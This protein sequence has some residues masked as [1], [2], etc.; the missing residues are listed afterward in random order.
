LSS[1][2]RTAD[3]PPLV[4]E[5]LEKF[6]RLQ[7]GPWLERARRLIDGTVPSAQEADAISS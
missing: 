5:A 7:A 1:V 4:E 2:G 6:T 3:A